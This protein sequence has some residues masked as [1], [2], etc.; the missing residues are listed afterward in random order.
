MTDTPAISQKLEAEPSD[1]KTIASV[2][3]SARPTATDRALVALG[4][5]AGQI[6]V[7]D[8]GAGKQLVPYKDRKAVHLLFDPT[9]SRAKSFPTRKNSICRRSFRVWEIWMRTF[10]M[11]TLRRFFLPKKS[12]IWPFDCAM[13]AT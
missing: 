7:A 10:A 3:D 12:T 5:N 1:T 13:R 8:K 2:P 9:P 4:K 11:P 6:V